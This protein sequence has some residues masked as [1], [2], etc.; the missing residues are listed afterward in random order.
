MVI[1][2]TPES[3][4]DHINFEGPLHVIMH[5]GITCG[6]CKMTM[7]QY[8]LVEKH[9]VEHNATNVRF[10]KFH[11]WE[12]N[13][14][15]FIDNNNLKTDGVPCFKYYY[16]KEKIDEVVS[17][18]QDANVLKRKILDVCDAIYLTMGGFDLYKTY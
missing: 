15:E 8:E 10:Y 3:Y 17:S 12:Q 16:N 18:Y 5:Y 4:F 9:F 13:Y 1:E 6:P 11:Q 14:R 7:P 2:L